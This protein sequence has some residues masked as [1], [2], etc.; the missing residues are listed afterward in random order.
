MQHGNDLLTSSQTL[1]SAARD[2][3]TYG[4]LNSRFSVVCLL[5]VRKLPSR[6]IL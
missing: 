3:K 4:S 1:Y 2:D 5:I 6:G